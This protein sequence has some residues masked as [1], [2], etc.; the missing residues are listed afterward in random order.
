MLTSTLV[1]L[2]LLSADHPA[3]LVSSGD[4]KTAYNIAH[5]EEDREQPWLKWE[6]A[7]DEVTE[8]DMEEFARAPASTNLHS[9]SG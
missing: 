2:G 8:D 9:A 1:W 7:V 3:N 6:R 4:E 5:A